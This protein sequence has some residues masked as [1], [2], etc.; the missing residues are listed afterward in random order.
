MTHVATMA[1]RDDSDGHGVAAGLAGSLHGGPWRLSEMTRWPPD[2]GH[3]MV[4][5]GSR[6]H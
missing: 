3:H 2:E 4:I 1:A 6:R 5:H